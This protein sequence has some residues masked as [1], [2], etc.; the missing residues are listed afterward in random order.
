MKILRLF[1]LLMALAGL[2]GCPEEPCFGGGVS[3]PPPVQPGIILV[4]EETTLRLAPNFVGGCDPEDTPT[5][6]SLTVEVSDPDNQPVEHIASLGSPASG[7]STLR[8]T[9]RKPGR[10]HIF[11]AFDPVGG[12][13]QFDVHAAMDYSRAEPALTLPR[14]CIR[15]ERTGQGA[16]VCDQDV[17]RDGAPVQSFTDSRLAVV[18]DVVW[19]VSPSRIQRYVDSGSA[20]TLTATLE[21]GRGPPEVLQASEDELVVISSSVV[22]RFTFSGTALAITGT[23]LWTP[24]SIPISF[25]GPMVLAVRTGDRLGIVTRTGLG[26]T[27]GYQVC[28][29]GLEAGR[30]VRTTEACSS[31]SGV[32]VG[33]EPDALWVGDPQSFSE[34]DFTSLR[35]VQWTA[36]G[37]VEQALLPLSFNLK[38]GV[39]PFNSRQTVAPTLT[40]TTAAINPLPITTV[41]VYSAD[42][43]SIL[44]EHLGLGTPE[45]L[46]SQRLI[47]APP[48]AS[49]PNGSTVVRVRPSAP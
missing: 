5:P 14:P 48:F 42:R 33:Y 3:V 1:P 16:F 26:S 12:V 47:W 41:A 24:T 4:G 49:Q 28:P 39:H 19:A 25:S 32:V 20:L 46:A 17:L 18:G 43:R 9:A 35:Y 34:T 37:L 10:H 13:Q 27:T 30:F 22:Q 6:S 29:H 8:F 40:S 23:A 44:M 38:L 11:A 2:S 36:T 15:L 45:T 7:V 21:N 31:F